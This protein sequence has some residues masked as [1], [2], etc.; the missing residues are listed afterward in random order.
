MKQGKA[1]STPFAGFAETA[2][3][4]AATTKRNEKAAL[5]GRYFATLSDGELAVA[6]RFFSGQIFPQWDQRTT[7]VGG[8][9]LLTA[10][11]AVT[12]MTRDD[13]TSRLV[14][15]GDL[16]D[17]A[18]DAFAVAGRTAKRQPALSLEQVFAAFE[19]LAATSGSKLKT[20]SLAELLSKT[21]PVEAKYL[22]KLLAGDLR[23][24]LKEGSV[25]DALARL[26]GLETGQV[27]WA[28]ML[29]GDVGETAL[30][31]RHGRLA[32]ARMRLFHPIKFM[33]AT[34]ASGLEDVE[35]QMPDEFVVEDK[36]DGIRAQA[37]IAPVDQS[38][39]PAHGVM[40]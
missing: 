16:G 32:D 37:H 1:Q 35:R 33:L 17:V 2:E 25:E 13:L 39:K 30:L 24:G 8:S 20:A 22:V 36:F 4:T 10:I 29:T 7:N 27:Q 31:A 15:R 21:A 40:E 3:A 5:L 18:Q 38:D 26:H 34:P 9:A 6:A 12:E 11:G 14:A 28:N 23:I 19:Q